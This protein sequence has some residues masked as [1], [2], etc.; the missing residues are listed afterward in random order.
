MHVFDHHGVT[1]T[2][3]GSTLRR[4][5]KCCVAFG[6]THE[7]RLVQINLKLA[8]WQNS[9]VI[10]SR[11][12]PLTLNN[13]VTDGWDELSGKT[14]KAANTR[15]MFPFVESLFREC[16]DVDCPF[17]KDVVRCIT[18]L[19]AVYHILYNSELFLTEQQ[20]VDLDTHLCK[21]GKY[22]MACREHSKRLGEYAFQVKPKA[23]YAQHIGSQSRLINSRYTQ[24]YAE[25]SLMGKVSAVWHK[26]CNGKYHGCIQRVVLVKYLLW[27]SIHLDL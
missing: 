22:H 24:C 21:M 18:H 6:T 5:V 15:Q 16:M 13:L 14:V 8:A 3:T 27:L 10:S 9:R 2:L 7:E 4:I 25:E 23:H 1:S 11:M 20:K 19:N 26:S 17:D 12:P